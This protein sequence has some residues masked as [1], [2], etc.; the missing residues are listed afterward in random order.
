M[1][2]STKP[3]SQRSDLQ[4]H[5]DAL[6]RELGVNRAHYRDGT[7]RVHTPITGET[8]GHVQ[9]TSASEAAAAIEAAH[10]AFRVWRLVPA[11][12][13]GELIRLLGEELRAKK[14]ALGRLVS[15]EVGKILSEGLGEVQEMIDICDFAVGL[16]RQLYGLTI[17]TERAEHRMMESWHPL[18]V[19]G[20]ISAFNFPV[21]V[22][23]WNSALALVCGNSIV[24]KPSEKTPLTALA[25]EALVER[26]VKRFRQEGGVAPDG[27]SAVLFGGRDIGELLV[28][29]ARVALVSATGSTEM[30]RAVGPRLAKRFARAILELGGNNAAIVAPTA[31]LDLTLH[32]IAF[33]AMGTAGQRCTTLRRLFVHESVYE[34]FVSRLKRAY[35][36]VTVGNPL[37]T[38]TLVGPLIDAAAYRGMQNALDAARAA[39]GAVHGGER[40][41][42]EGAA[43]AHYVRPALVEMAAQTGPVEHETFAPVLYVMKYSDFNAVLEVHNAIAQ[44]LSSSIFTNDLRE[45][46]AFFSARGS[47]CGIANV[48]IGPSGAEIGGAFGGEKETGGGRESGSDAWKA[49]MRRATNT[50]NYGRTLPLAQG[51]KFDVV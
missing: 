12:K 29:H 16:S 42:I 40:V 21:A 51:V 46:E 17:A 22:W 5:V 26:A 44:G 8:I 2:A 47:D 34:T 14:E 20:I 6:L 32:G 43:D 25:T 39:G 50:I 10:T 31:D 45:A 24:W 41:A 48:N 7:F 9:E 36:S 3:Q 13:R 35:A 30:G 11:P 23:A 28:D 19:T 27:L 15:I 1:S 33:A 4:G 37:Q 18:G 38:D 49:Y